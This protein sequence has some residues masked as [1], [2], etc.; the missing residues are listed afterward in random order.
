MARCPLPR[1]SRKKDTTAAP[2]RYPN[3]QEWAAWPP[4]KGPGTTAR[5]LRRGRNGREWS[6]QKRGSAQ[7]RNTRSPRGGLPPQAC[8]LPRGSVG[9]GGPGWQG[10]RDRG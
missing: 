5:D 2:F 6:R 4:L 8:A 9:G 1:E 10:H 7:G 3:G